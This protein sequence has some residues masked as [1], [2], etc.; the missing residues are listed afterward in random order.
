MATYTSTILIRKFL[1]KFKITKSK[2]YCLWK[3]V[4]VK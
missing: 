4:L 2:F 3:F 1:S